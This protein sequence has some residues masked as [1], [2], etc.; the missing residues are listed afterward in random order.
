MFLNDP[1]PAGETRA[2]CVAIHDVAPATWPDCLCLLRAL[3]EVAD[4]PLTWLLVPHFHGSPAR[5]PAC[6]NML[7][8]LLADGHELA[9]HG[10]THADAGGAPAGWRERFLRHTYARGE[11]EFA[12]I[13]T[14]HACRLIDGGLAW[15]AQRGWPV[16][17]FVAPAWLLGASAWAALDGY[18]FSY[19]TTW[20]RFHWRIQGGMRDGGI[21]S[22]ALVYA[23]RNRAGRAASPMLASA[24][25][26]AMNKAPL[27]RVALHPRDAHHPQLIRHAQGLVEGLLADRVAMTKLA[28]ARS[29]LAG[30]AVSAA[31]IATSIATSTAT[32]SRHTPSAGARTLHENADSR[33]GRPLP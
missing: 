33:S 24:M 19:T 9:M 30:A 11:G 4:L 26:A 15:F 2:L 29:R 14:G 28:F 6:D 22:P 21:L 25:A 10:Y 12:A 32:S 27:V 1:A 16:H 13:D 20:P 7:T 31:S 23:E 8:R 17:G 18:A 3:R 5:S